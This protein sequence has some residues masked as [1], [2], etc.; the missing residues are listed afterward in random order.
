MEGIK[1]EDHHED[2]QQRH[3]YSN[4]LKSNNQPRQYLTRSKNKANEAETK[5]ENTEFVFLRGDGKQFTPVFKQFEFILCNNLEELCLDP[6]KKYN[7]SWTIT[8]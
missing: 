6:E 4:Q 7:S 3:F 8:K 1:Q 2:I 5:A